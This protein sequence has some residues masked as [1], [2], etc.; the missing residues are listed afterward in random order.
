MVL[1]QSLCRHFYLSGYIYS[2]SDI[3][4]PEKGRHTMH[5][6]KRLA[7]ALWGERLSQLVPKVLSL[8]WLLGEFGIVTGLITSLICK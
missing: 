3:P 1:S 8:L 4:A 2:I 7:G 6:V 5:T